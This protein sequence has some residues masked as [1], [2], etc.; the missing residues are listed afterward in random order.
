MPRRESGA[1]C[2]ACIRGY[3]KDSLSLDR[4]TRSSSSISSPLSKDDLAKYQVPLQHAIDFDA[5]VM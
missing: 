5:R 3:E 2:G 4:S 1:E